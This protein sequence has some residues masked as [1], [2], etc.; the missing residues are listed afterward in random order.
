MNKI[1]LIGLLLILLY[2]YINR[3]NMIGSYEP[4][5]KEIQNLDY[6]RDKEEI[7]Q[8]DELGEFPTPQISRGFKKLSKE[9]MKPINNGKDFF[10][11]E[12]NPA[13]IRDVPSNMIKERV[14]FP[15]YFRKDRLSGNDI[16]TG[17][18][19][20][21]NTNDEPDNSW[22][23]SNVSDHPKF[24][25]S[26]IKDELTNVGAFFDKNNQYNDKT[27]STTD[28]LPGDSC[29]IDKRGM[30]F[31]ED[32][33]RLQNIPP[34]LIT[35]VNKCYALNTV[36]MYK[37]KHKKPKEYVSFNQEKIDN[38]TLGVWSYSDD[39]VMNGGNFFNEVFPSRQKN[40]TVSP[41]IKGL[42]GSCGI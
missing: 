13:I 30:K 39:R 36:G 40:E 9:V 15:D 14:Y 20:P 23:D 1:I 38:E 19:R 4:S 11:K 33:T 34:S 8:V 25:T 32:N 5:Q 27:S 37:D 10:P 26:D 17:E 35:D 16:G 2:L 31:C 21:F 28:V 12:K 7:I 42:V 29:Y 41:K 6:V 18:M 22:T 24:Y 3:G